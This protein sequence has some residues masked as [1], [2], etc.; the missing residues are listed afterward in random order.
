M[1]ASTNAADATDVQRKAFPNVSAETVCRHLAA[2]GLKAYVRRRKPLLTK[3]HTKKHKKWAELHLNWTAEQWSQVIFS[4][5]SKFNLVGSD[6]KQYCW[7]RP[8]EE[9]DT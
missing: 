3:T 8:G 6:G 1:L 7:R 9:F 2:S 4:D 5:E